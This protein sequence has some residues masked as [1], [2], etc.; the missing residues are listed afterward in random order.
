[1]EEKVEDS[2]DIGW[3]WTLPGFLLSG[4]WVR[5]DRKNFDHIK[6]HQ[7]FQVPKVEVA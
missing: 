1:M 2:M 7:E 5:L 6:I 4:A 3:N